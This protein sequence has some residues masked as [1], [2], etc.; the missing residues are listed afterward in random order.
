MTEPGNQDHDG[1]ANAFLV[2]YLEDLDGDT[3]RP[4]EAYQHEF[5]GYEDLIAG[6][7]AELLGDTET[8]APATEL[9]AAELEVGTALSLLDEACR[10]VGPYTLRHCLG[11]GA[12]GRSIL[13]SS[14]SPFGVSSR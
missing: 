6:K 5:P 3:V 4:V 8:E 9:F 11:E 10:D 13:L 1:I 2:R 12:W 7:Y 14:A